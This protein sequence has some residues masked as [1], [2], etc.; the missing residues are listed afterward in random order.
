[1]ATHFTGELAEVYGSVQGTS[2]LNTP[3]TVASGNLII[4]ETTPGRAGRVA[5]IEVNAAT[6][7][8][9][10]IYG[11]QPSCTSGAYCWESE[12]CS[13]GCTQ[14][15]PPLSCA[16]T[17][18]LCVSSIRCSAVSCAA[19]ST[20]STGLKYRFIISFYVTVANAPFTYLLDYLTAEVYEG[21]RI[22]FGCA[23]SADCGTGAAK[24]NS[25]NVSLGETRDQLASYSAASVATPGNFSSSKHLVRVIVRDDP[26]AYLSYG[27]NCSVASSVPT[28][29]VPLPFTAAT[30]AY[31]LQGLYNLTYTVS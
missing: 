15:S 10:A 5:R 21:E 1:M 9:V 2:S 19:T 11:V 14:S 31:V 23:V 12:N 16:S 7:G 28:A 17:S 24:I 27:I 3:T 18:A 29:N 26:V 25:R 13:S 30:Q 6:T 4:L 22:A 20:P 8:W